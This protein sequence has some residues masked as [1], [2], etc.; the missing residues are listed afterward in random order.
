MKSLF[1]VF[2]LL[3][4][5]S[6]GKDGKNGVNGLDGLNGKDGV[7]AQEIKVVTFCKS[8]EYN[9]METGLCI[10]GKPY[11]VL[12]QNGLASL[13]EVPNGDYV[14]TDGSDC[15]FTIDENTCK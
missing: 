14:T 9:Y 6:C 1:T 2:V 13:I 3:T 5:V 4:L 8:K 11:A 10:D 15:R 7:D 12:S